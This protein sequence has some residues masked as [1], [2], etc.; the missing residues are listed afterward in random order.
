MCKHA[1]FSMYKMIPQFHFHIVGCEAAAYS[2]SKKTIHCERKAK[3]HCLTQELYLLWLFPFLVPLR[4][5]VFSI[6]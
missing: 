6:H 1:Y 4:L 3:G 5:L 2:F